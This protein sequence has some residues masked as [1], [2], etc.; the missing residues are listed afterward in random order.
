M[1]RIRTFLHAAA[2]VA[3]LAVGAHAQ[4][5]PFGTGWTL[6]AA[7][8][9]LQFSSI[10]NGSTI[11][12]SSFATYS[13]GI[14]PAG[15]ATLEIL[16]DSVD[17]KV[18]LRNVRMRFLFFETFQHPQAS[19][20][21]TI[22]PNMVADLVE[23]RRKTVTLPFTLTL[24][25]VT[26]PMEARVALTLIGDDIVAVS[27]A[28]PITVGV[29]DFNLM[30]GLQKLEEA[31]NVTIVPSSTVN[32]DF[33]FRARPGAAPEAVAAV[34]PPAQDAPATRVAL[35]AEGD[36]SLEAC[37]GRFEILSRTDDIY[38][39]TGSARL[40]DASF[41]L[42]DQVADIVNRCPGLNIQ[43]SGHTDNVGSRAY[44]QQLSERRASSVVEYLQSKGVGLGRMSAVGMGEDKPIAAND[45]SEGRLKNRRIEFAVEG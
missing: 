35:E 33:I 19:V 44:N 20:A 37:I 45:T 7:A 5:D 10:K 40:E 29:A 23:V 34:E 30:P 32:F 3:G 38:F 15:E 27:T 42:L 25:G 4:A 12:T 21:A 9:S 1:S 13:G 14:S 39:A 31:A 43:I 16:L 2:A 11:E 26:K 24:H 36:F 17:T 28:E 22:T 41:P 8:S 6:D 18:D